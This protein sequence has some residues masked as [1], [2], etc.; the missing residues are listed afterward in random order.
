[1]PSPKSLPRGF[2]A[3]IPIPSFSE[4]EKAAL[5]VGSE[6]TFLQLPDGFAMDNE[7]IKQV[8]TPET[9]ILSICNPHSP[10]GRLDSKEELLELVDF[11]HKK[12]LSSASTKTTS[13]SRRK[14]E[15]TR[16][17]ASSKN[18]RTCLSSGQLPSSTGWLASIRLRLAV[19]KFSWETE[20]CTV[21]L[22]HQQPRELRYICSVQRHRIHREH[23]ETIAKERE[24]LA[25]SLSEIESLHVYPSVT[26]FLLVKILNGKI[27]ST[28]LKEALAK[29]RM[30]IRDCC[31]F[32][33]LDDSYFRVT[34]RSAK[35]NQKLVQ[36][37]KQ[38]IDGLFLSQ[39]S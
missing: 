23:Q 13:N 39:T 4:Y 21:A 37:I 24:A 25:K 2:K 33:G 16:W 22:E 32:M 3:L 38:I 20:K 35:D 28:K 30:L 27:T 14:A 36:T 19:A 26:N 7:K 17:Q 31:T 8:I 9:K 1:M 12:A 34:V 29:K 5:R 15:K 18:M 10:S 6:V 11:C